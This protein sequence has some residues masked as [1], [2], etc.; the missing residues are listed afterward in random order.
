[1]IH[2]QTIIPFCLANVLLCHGC[3]VAFGPHPS[4]PSSSAGPEMLVEEHA[5]EEVLP[6]A[7]QAPPSPSR[8][9]HVA[10]TGR[11]GA[12]VAMYVTWYCSV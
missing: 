12:Y 11:S 9:R 4:A 6:A 3:F 5:S 2:S 10:D 7:V 1:M 8:R